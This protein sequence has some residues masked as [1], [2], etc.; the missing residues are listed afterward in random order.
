MTPTIAPSHIRRTQPLRGWAMACAALV[1]C[2]SGSLA[3]VSPALAADAPTAAEA[4]VPVLDRAK[5]DALLATPG[6]VL[7][8]D[9]RRADEISTIGGFPAFLNI[10]AADLERLLAY[11]PKGRTIVTVSNHAHRAQRAAVVL[12]SHG[13]KV[14]GAAGVQDYEAQGGVLV[15][16]KP[17]PAPGA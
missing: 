16:K 6:K 7:V 1:V 8:I 13:Y 14:A 10:Q 17:A 15:G 2:A 11:V 4:A 12:E 3:S 9:V 5:I